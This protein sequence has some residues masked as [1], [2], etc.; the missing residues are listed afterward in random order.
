[1]YI[2]EVRIFSIFNPDRF[3]G[4]SISIP[5]KTSESL[6]FSD[7]FWGCRNGTFG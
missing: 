1:M 3:R 6:L 7:V 5:L 4:F 2:S